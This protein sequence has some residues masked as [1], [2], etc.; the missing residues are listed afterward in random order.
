[1]SLGGSERNSSI[2]P[3]L[4]ACE[5]ELCSTV[6]AMATVCAFILAGGKS[7]RMG[8]DKALLRFG[9]ETLLESA[10]NRL[11]AVTDHVFIVGSRPELSAYAPV[12][13]DAYAER[14]PLAGIYSALRG[15]PGELNLML[16]VDMPFVPLEFLKK[17]LTAA[18]QSHAMVTFPAGKDGSQPLCAVYRREFVAIAQEALES[19]NYKIDPLFGK[20][21]TCIIDEQKLESWGFNPGIFMNLNSPDDLRRAQV[22]AQGRGEP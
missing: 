21:E 2:K 9:A 7:S 19:G 17:L 11:R 6:T 22:T 1:M 8:S 20:T 4:L 16:A 18:G 13:P 3:R 15:S 14:G 5:N 12:I 10:L